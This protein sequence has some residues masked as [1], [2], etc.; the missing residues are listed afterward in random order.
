ML[1]LL[2]RWVQERGYST[3]VCKKILTKIFIPIFEF[4]FWNASKQVLPV[5]APKLW[6][7][8][9]KIPFWGEKSNVCQKW[10]IRPPKKKQT[11]KQNKTKQN[12]KKKPCFMGGQTCQVG[13]ASQVF[14]IYLYTYIYIYFL[15]SGSKNDLK[16]TQIKKKKKRKKNLTFFAEKFWE[17]ILTYFQKFLAKIF[18]FWSKN[19]WFYKIL[20]KFF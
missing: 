12:Q 15:I 16:N 4:S 5:V 1:N 18:K 19:G 17:N 8:G 13:S 9:A 14:F 3:N 2:T 10:L 11:N 7:G 6:G 20:E